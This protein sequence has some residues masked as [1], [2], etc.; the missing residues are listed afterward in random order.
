MSRFAA[1]HLRLLGRTLAGKSESGFI[2]SFQSVIANIVILTVNVLTGI[3]T[4]RLLGP[5]DKGVQAAIILW[6]G[7]LI[8][9][10]TIGLPTALLYHI[11]K[12]AARASALITVAIVLGFL[13]SLLTVSLGVI[14]VP[15]WLANYDTQTIRITQFYL[16]FVPVAVTASIYTSAVQATGNFQL[17]NGFRLLQP[18]ITLSILI[19]LALTNMLSASTAAAAFLCPALPALIWLWAHTR[20]LYTFS[21]TQFRETCH[22]LFSYGL[23]SYSGDVLAVASSQLDKVIIVSLLSP[24]SMGLYSVAFS[25]AKML[26]VFEAAVVSVLLPKTIGQP[27][28]EVRALLGRAVR[29]ST[30]VTSAAAVILIL[31]GP[32]LINLF[33]GDAF[34]AATI[35]FWILA[36]DSVLGGLAGLLGQ[37]FYAVGKPEIMIFRHAISLAVTVPGMIILGGNYGIVGV[38]SA[39]LLESVV[40][41]VLTLSAF[42]TIL[43]I[44]IP[45]LWA[46]AEDLSYLNKLWLAWRQSR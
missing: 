20:H 16:V 9:L 32:R 12:S 18:L 3:V 8:S 34:L 2:S 19:I 30:L 46:P 21:F 10:S 5:N 28:T 6:P 13:V 23:R 29:V 22:D 43:K 35:V 26:F 15:N 4:A 36:V 24:T 25:L 45:R 14:F 1:G 7:I 42:P 44:P 27:I 40:M 31:I 33:Y 11:K 38:A 39:V 37:V 41:V 17:Y